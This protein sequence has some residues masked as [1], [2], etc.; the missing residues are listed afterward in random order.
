MG[1]ADAMIRDR[2]ARAQ[3]YRPLGTPEVEVKIDCQVD[4][5]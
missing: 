2:L 3:R 1:H 5:A 4:G